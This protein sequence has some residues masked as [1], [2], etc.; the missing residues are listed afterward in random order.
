MSSRK[1]SAACAAAAQ[2]LVERLLQ[3]GP[4]Q[5]FDGP[6]AR[7]R[8]RRRRQH[9]QRVGACAPR[10][11]VTQHTIVRQCA[12]EIFSNE[13]IPF[14]QAARSVPRFAECDIFRKDSRHGSSS[15][16]EDTYDV[17]AVPEDF[18]KRTS[19][20]RRERE[21]EKQSVKVE[22]LGSRA[23]SQAQVGVESTES[24]SQAAHALVA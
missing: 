13:P 19:L 11:Q 9:R 7:R 23:A 1:Q 18:A 17:R 4:C 2:R 8:Q 16:S 5:R 6:V 15:C 3:H 12:R 24:D 21:R 22:P 20:S 10:T 14:Q